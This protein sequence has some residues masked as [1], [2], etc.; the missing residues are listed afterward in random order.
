MADPRTSI[1][2]PAKIKRRVEKMAKAHR[3]PIGWTTK[4]VMLAEA[5]LDRLDGKPS[6]PRLPQP[7]E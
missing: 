2:V 7:S 4:L 1:A 3:P 6:A 5:E